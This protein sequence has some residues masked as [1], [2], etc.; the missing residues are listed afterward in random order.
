MNH[1]WNKRDV[2]DAKKSI[3]LGDTLAASGS[4]SL[5]LT[6]TEGDDEVGNNSVLSLTAT[7]GDHDTPTI[8]LSKLRT[9]SSTRISIIYKH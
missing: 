8:R 2:L 3:V 5:D 9:V 1:S 7:V 4:T 6:N